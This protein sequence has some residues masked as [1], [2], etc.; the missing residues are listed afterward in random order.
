MA[1]AQKAEIGK[2]QNVLRAI[3]IANGDGR[4]SSSDTKKYEEVAWLLPHLVNA[5]DNCSRKDQLMVLDC[6]VGKGY[7]LF[8]LD[9][10]LGRDD[11]SYYGVDT[12]PDI[13]E[14]CHRIARELDRRNM[15]F[16]RERILDANLERADVLYSLHACDKATD[17]AIAKGIGLQAEA[18]LVVPCCHKHVQKQL[19]RNPTEHPLSYTV[20]RFGLLRDQFG[21]MLCDAFRALAC[22]AYGYDIRLLQFVSPSVTPKNTLLIGAKVGKGSNRARTEFRKLR[23]TFGLDPEIGRLLGL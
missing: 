14:T 23:D 11:I 10:L 17:E 18:I 21:T 13:I 19:K 15:H 2:Y 8:L 6:C 12:N 20:D 9:A 5:I 7:T 3:G 16:F 4:I 1:I 22:C